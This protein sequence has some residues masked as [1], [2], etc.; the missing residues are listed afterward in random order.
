MLFCVTT[1]GR[2]RIFNKPRDSAMV[3]TAS[4]RT[5]LLALTKLMPLVGAVAAR[6]ENR[7]IWTPPALL[8]L[9]TGYSGFGVLP[10]LRGDVP[11]EVA[12]PMPV[13]LLPQP[14]PS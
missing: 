2:D 13:G 4:S 11:T 5:A 9:T 7:G 3:R 10:T 1:R 8:P 6:F 12:P 14:N